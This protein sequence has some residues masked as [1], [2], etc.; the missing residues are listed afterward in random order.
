MQLSHH[1]ARQKKGTKPCIPV[2]L[3]ALAAGSQQTVCPSDCKWSYLDLVIKQQIGMSSAPEVLFSAL[4]L[5]EV[6]G[7]SVSLSVK[8]STCSLTVNVILM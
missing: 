3:S 4:W 7:T 6:R 5:K 2:S 8:H 1:L